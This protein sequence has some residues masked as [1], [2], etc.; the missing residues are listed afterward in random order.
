MAKV[1][2]LATLDK[3][4]IACLDKVNEAQHGSALALWDLGEVI[5]L[6]AEQPQFVNAK[7][8]TYWKNLHAHLESIG[9]HLSAIKRAKRIR[10]KERD[11]VAGDDIY[12]AMGQSR[13]TKKDWIPL[14]PGA[15]LHKVEA[16]ACQ[17]LI[18]ICGT[19]ERMDEAIKRFRGDEGKKFA[20]KVKGVSG[21]KLRA[22]L[23]P[24]TTEIAQKRRAEFISDPL[25][26]VGGW[27]KVTQAARSEYDETVAA[28]KAKTQEA[29]ATTTDSLL[30]GLARSHERTQIGRADEQLSYKIVAIAQE[31][32]KQKHSV[33][34]Y[35][36]AHTDEAVDTVLE[37]QKQVQSLLAI[38]TQPSTPV[39][40]NNN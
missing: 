2:K 7:G 25:G 30:V 11:A 14:L 34:G 19:D 16:H 20:R 23:K 22:A 39:A 10:K 28:I 18:E 9:I 38:P 17:R 35:N 3:Q 6:M 40:G 12:G 1:L 31:Y 13:E 27:V 15:N 37:I 33:K 26:F 32:L 4:A 21:K 24:I 36:A 29:L 5:R 8:K